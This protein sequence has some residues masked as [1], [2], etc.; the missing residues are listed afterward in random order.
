MDNYLDRI[1]NNDQKYLISIV[2]PVWNEDKTIYSILNSL[3]INDKI[4]IIVIDDY[5]H[6]NSVYEIEKA[7]KH[8]E[9]KLYNIIKIKD[10]VTLF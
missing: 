4:E 7:Q 10:T 3:P 5:S 1:K 9:I 6:D 8:R 2:I